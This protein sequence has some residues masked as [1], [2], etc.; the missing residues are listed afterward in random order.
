MDDHKKRTF[1]WK[2]SYSSIP[3]EYAE[4]RLNVRFSDLGNAAV[5]VNRLIDIVSITDKTTQIKH[6]IYDRML[7]LIETEDYPQGAINPFKEAS[8]SDI[9]GTVL[10]C[11][12]ASFKREEKRSNIKLR[13]E[14]AI[15]SPNGDTGGIEEYVIVD[16]ISVAN[17]KIVL[18][19]EA[20]RD[21]MD[22]CLTQCLLA[23]RDAYDTNT[24]NKINTDAVYGFTTEGVHW[25]LIIYD[26]KTFKMS[27]EMKTMAPDMAVDKANWMADCSIIV[28]VLYYVLKNS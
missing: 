2:E 15:V 4:Q 17:D 10:I 8:I 3:Q 7:E 25:R 5:K 28:D 1:R 19:V 11:C 12:I 24:T 16:I 21:N 26:G 13:R 18:V 14:R 23:M 20:K 27:D 9:V 22:K 6:K